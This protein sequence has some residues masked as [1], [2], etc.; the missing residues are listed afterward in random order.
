MQ[1]NS[2]TTNKPSTTSS[3]F[4]N[5]KTRKMSQ[6]VGQAKYSLLGKSF[7]TKSEV[8]DVQP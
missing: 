4:P 8:P 6:D 7:C 2:N 1:A 5:L 3:L